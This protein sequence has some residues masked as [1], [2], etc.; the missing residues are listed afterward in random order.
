MTATSIKTPNIIKVFFNFSLF[1]NKIIEPSP[2]LTI[3]PAR[4]VPNEILPASNKLAMITEL[5]QLGIKPINTANNGPKYLPLS[6][7]LAKVSSPIK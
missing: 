7:K 4:A 5:T 2:Q 6:K 3:K 1:F